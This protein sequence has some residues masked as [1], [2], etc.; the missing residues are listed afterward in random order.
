M[1]DKATRTRERIE[2]VALALFEARGFDE[3]T[4]AEIAAAAEISEMTFFRYFP[5]KEA[6]VLDD[7]YDPVL[8][9]AI[10]NQ[11]RGESA[12]TRV[13][14]GILAAWRELPEPADERTRQKVKIAAATPSL[15]GGMW[16]NNVS[17]E[18]VIVEQLRLDG[19]QE[20][21]ARVAAAACL[22]ALMSALLEW[23]R[24]DSGLLSE[25]IEFALAIVSG[26]TSGVIAT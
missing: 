10:A 9:A 13:A 19:T 3:T 20:L 16:T 2:G 14:H 18:N 12:I 15:R 22:A 21:E 25:H 17:T 8:A 1:S 6:V 4:V 23:A 24:S 7:P 11:P 5:S 26:T